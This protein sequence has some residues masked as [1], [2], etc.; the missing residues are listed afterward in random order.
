MSPK[1]RCTEKWVCMTSVA[2]PS[3]THPLS[4]TGHSWP[5]LQETLPSLHFRDRA[6]PFSLPPGPLLLRSARLAIPPCLI[7]AYPSS[8]GIGTWT[9][10]LPTPHLFPGIHRELRFSVQSPQGGRPDTHLIPELQTSP[11]DTAT[12][13]SDP[14]PYSMCPKGLFPHLRN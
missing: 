3:C 10:S 8:P 5:S 6:L 4:S 2:I 1:H 11:P 7:S 9:F 13:I 14:K 12:W